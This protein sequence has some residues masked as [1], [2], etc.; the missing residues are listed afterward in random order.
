MSLASLARQSAQRSAV[1]VSRE[2]STV[3]GLQSGE[4]GGEPPTALEQLTQYIPTETVTLFI[5]AVSAWTAL[6]QEEAWLWLGPWGLIG[7]FTVLTPIMFWIAALATFAEHKKAKKIPE[8]ATFS[9]PFFDMVA[10]T[11]A[12]F[13]W[14]LAVPGLFD[15]AAVLQVLA[16]FAAVLVSWLLSKAASIFGEG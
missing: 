5:A 13:V 6:H 11:I 2:R 15:G 10:A 9:P 14:S 4:G 1:T 12:F 8:D 16:A 7:A 3:S